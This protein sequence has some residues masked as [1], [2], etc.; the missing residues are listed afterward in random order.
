[1]IKELKS[2]A[3]KQ[4]GKLVKQ[5]DMVGAVKKHINSL[6]AQD[7]LD[8]LGKQVRKDYKEVFKVIPHLE[9]LPTDIYCHIT[10]KDVHKTITMWSYSTP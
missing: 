1:M 4:R 2:V 8:K 7:Q 6:A 5:V 3:I 10:L 9:E